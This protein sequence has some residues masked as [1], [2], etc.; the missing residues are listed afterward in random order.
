[1]R[2]TIAGKHVVPET[3]LLP[4][5]SILIFTNP[6]SMLRRIVGIHGN[7][8]EKKEKMSNRRSGQHRSQGS[9]LGGSTDDELDDIHQATLE[10][11]GKPRIL[12]L[13]VQ[14]PRF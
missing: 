13:L 4:F 2:R 10:V 6:F 7:G 1:M 8:L 3:G 11:L 5:R 12:E 14:T 9:S